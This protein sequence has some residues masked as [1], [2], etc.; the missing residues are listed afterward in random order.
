MGEILVFILY[1]L[2][3]LCICLTVGEV[4]KK[5]LGIYY[6]HLMV[7]QHKNYVHIRSKT[8]DQ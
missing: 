6:Y 3:V 8:L 7:S 5:S 2:Y 1:C 4:V